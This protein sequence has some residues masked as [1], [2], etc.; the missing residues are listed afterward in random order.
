MNTKKTLVAYDPAKPRSGGSDF[1][2][3]VTGGDLPQFVGLKS[4]KASS[5]GVMTY[6][7]R[8]VTVNDM[9]AKLVESGRKIHDVQRTLKNIQ[10][11]IDMLQEFKIGNVL[12]LEPTT[13]NEHGFRLVLAA[14]MPVV[15]QLPLP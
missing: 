2:V 14:R 5:M 15:K 13:E 1:L 4:G 7:G 11:Y 6:V 12:R 8:E 3:P 10:A 9:F